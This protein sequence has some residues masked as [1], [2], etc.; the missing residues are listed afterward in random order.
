MGRHLRQRHLHRQYS[1]RRCAGPRVETDGG[2]CAGAGQDTPHLDHQQRSLRRR[3]QGRAIHRRHHVEP[4][5]YHRFRHGNVLHGYGALGQYHLLLPG[6]VVHRRR[7]FRLL[8]RRQRQDARQQHHCLR[9][10]QLH[11]Q[12]GRIL[13]RR[14]RLQR[15]LDLNGAERC[16]RP[17]GLSDAE[18]AGEYPHHQRQQGSDHARVQGD[19]KHFRQLRHRQQHDVVQLCLQSWGQR[20]LLRGCRAW[21]QHGGRRLRPRQ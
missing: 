20:P 10:F 6:E 12:S 18:N 14:V 21:Q 19:P 8:Q 9:R 2:R 3:L 17:H 11:R 1:R 5:G 16:Y 15:Q 13:E 7:G 4:A